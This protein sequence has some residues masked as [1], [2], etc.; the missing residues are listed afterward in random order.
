MT[1][2]PFTPANHH[3]KAVKGARTLIFALSAL[4]VL[5]AGLWLLPPDARAGAFT[6]FATAIAGLMMAVAGKASVDALAHGDGVGGAVAN[7]MTDKKP[8]G[9]Q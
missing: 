4:L 8:G 5:L 6:A 9:S 1:P 2:V 3:V 7:L